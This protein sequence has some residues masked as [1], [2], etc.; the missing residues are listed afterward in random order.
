MND[1]VRQFAALGFL[2]TLGVGAC[3][4]PCEKTLT[5]PGGIGGEDHVGG[6]TSIGGG[7][8]G[9]P[10]GEPCDGDSD[11]SSGFCVDQ[12]CC[13]SACSG[14]CETC[15]T[16]G[17]CTAVPG[18]SNPDGE[19][20]D[21][22]CS[23]AGWCAE[24]TPAWATGFAGGAIDSIGDVTVDGDTPV[25][26]IQFGDGLTLGNNSYSGAGLAVARFDALGAPTW[27]TAFAGMAGV[28]TIDT[29]PNGDIVLGGLLLTSMDFGGGPLTPTAPYDLFV[30]R[31]TASGNHVWSGVFGAPGEL[32]VTG[33]LECTAAGTFILGTFTQSLQFPPQPQMTSLGDLDIFMALLAPNG[34]GVWS[35]SFGDP[36]SQAGSNLAITPDGQLQISGSF[37]GNLDFGGGPLTAGAGT[38]QYLAKFDINGNHIW[39]RT[40]AEAPDMI[41]ED[42]A[43]DSTG[44]LYLA[45]RF[46]GSAAF[47]GDVLAAS[48]GTD[49]FL[50]KFDPLG[51]FAW[52]RSFGNFNNQ[53]AFGLAVSPEGF[54][55][56]GGYFT[57]SIQPGDRA[58]SSAGGDDAFLVAFSPAGDHV[59]SFAAGG[60]GDFQRV[61]AVELFDNGDFVAAGNFNGL[62]S[63]GNIPLTSTGETDIFLTRITR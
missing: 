10:L 33:G 9:T 38:T 5:C 21:A 39:S 36:G 54:V 59:W 4:I 17:L 42:F 28:A 60:P 27:S 52:A 24:G 57:G 40:V 32:E 6:G 1:V 50:A 30:A 61:T 35:K 25:A 43:F 46:E 8:G 13:E 29:C 62:M 14:T 56:L 37:D 12:V 34:T 49:A 16:S 58:I 48:G 22:V 26:A 47:D 41:S 2:A 3:D 53:S 18:G 55:V 31:I 19:C 7:T 45:G 23:G 20:G 11:C 51:E 63:V 15:D 44:N